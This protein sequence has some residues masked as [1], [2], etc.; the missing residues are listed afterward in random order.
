MRDRTSPEASAR[1]TTDPEAAD[2][3]T[4]SK[5]GSSARSGAGSPRD[6]A[7]G[8]PRGNVVVPANLAGPDL[9][10]NHRQRDG[11]T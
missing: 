10:A 1:P 5:P 6:A 2:L 7:A 8:L 4:A 9:H 3:S 11:V